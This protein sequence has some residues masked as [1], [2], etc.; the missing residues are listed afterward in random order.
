MIE[1]DRDCSKLSILSLYLFK[2]PTP[3]PPLQTLKLF[4]LDWPGKTENGGGRA[5]RTGGCKH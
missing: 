5:I 4:L 2:P 1:T 3:L